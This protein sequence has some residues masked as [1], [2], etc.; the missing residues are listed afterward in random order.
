MSISPQFPH[1]RGFS[2]AILLANDASGLL[3]VGMQSGG[4]S[5][6]VDLD[7]Q[8]VRQGIDFSGRIVVQVASP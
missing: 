6:L 4:D 1:R 3:A 8:K 5:P 2:C 7:L